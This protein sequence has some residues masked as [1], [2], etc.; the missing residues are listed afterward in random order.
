[1]ATNMPGN[2]GITIAIDPARAAEL[3]RN[4]TSAESAASQI[5][6]GM[7]LVAVFGAVVVIVVARFFLS[8]GASMVV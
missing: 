2:S 8:R 3:A 1:M 6:D 4:L 7:G 5:L